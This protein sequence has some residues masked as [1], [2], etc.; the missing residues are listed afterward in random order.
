MNNLR[1][2]NGGGT[3]EA[4]QAQLSDATQAL[5]ALQNELNSI[6]A[7]IREAARHGDAETLRRLRHRQ[8]DL[9]LD[10]WAARVQE[11]RARVAH[12]EAQKKAERVEVEQFECEELQPAAARWR[13]AEEV[14]KMRSGELSDMQMR[15]AILRSGLDLTGK[16][17]FD[18]RRDLEAIVSE[19][20]RAG[21]SSAD[22]VA[23]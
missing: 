11:L 10:L 12:L 4:A 2:V 17:L 21:G 20:V 1:A 5:G 22:S 14:L 15:G 18:A 16:Q 19:A 8:I 7:Q 13:E 3:L 9:D 23:V 6:P